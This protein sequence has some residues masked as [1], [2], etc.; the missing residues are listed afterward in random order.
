MAEALQ[1]TS[2]GSR[3]RLISTTRLPD[4]PGVE[5]TS[6]LA[7]EPS[8]PLSP[9]FLQQMT[10]VLTAIAAVLAARVLLLLSV[11]GAFVLAWAAIQN[12][13]PYRLAVTIIFDL[14]VVGSVTYLY[15]QKG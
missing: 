12:P 6:P 3:V 11:M 4:D 14:G 7:V 2:A 15:L 8:T 1:T 9:V 10:A 13:D 5:P